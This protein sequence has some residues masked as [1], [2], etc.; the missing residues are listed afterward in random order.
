MLGAGNPGRRWWLLSL[1][2]VL[3][4]IS[5]LEGVARAQT[6]YA[7]E[8][9]DLTIYSA[10]HRQI[11]GHSHYEITVVD[12]GAEIRGE[13]RYLD[14]ETD[15][16]R[17]RIEFSTPGQRPTL[18]SFKHIFF[19][20]GGELRMETQADF[21]SGAAYC[22][23]YED[24]GTQPVTETI[25]FPP[26]TYAG[27]TTL[28]PIEYGLRHGQQDRIRFHVFSCAPKPRVFELDASAD[29]TQSKW[30]SYDGNAT[31]MRVRPDLGWLTVLAVP[32]LPRF[33]E[34]FDPDHNWRYLG[35]TTERFYKGP[36]VDLVREFEPRDGHKE[37][38]AATPIP[39]APQGQ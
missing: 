9:S 34:W 14:G 20:A 11:V 31:R 6:W 37:Q 29:L 24:S 10:D 30:A 22:N 27:V 33:Y 19:L 21:K 7:F 35:G 36:T 13:A 38:P 1:A 15:V 4:A 3:C 16:E 39:Q 5:G 23:R 2:V 8:P 18:V 28:I 26:D 17:D 12:G 32:F 25:K